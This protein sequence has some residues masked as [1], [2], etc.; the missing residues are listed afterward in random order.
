MPIGDT[1]K[2]WGATWLLRGPRMLIVGYFIVLAVIAAA[3]LPT[4]VGT[5]RALDRQQST[6]DVA[7]SGASELLVSALNQETAM[8]GYVLTGDPSFL[9]PYQLGSAQSV[10]ATRDLHSVSLNAPFGSEV[11]TT[12][13][14]LHSWHELAARAISDVKGHE[15]GAAQAVS[16][17]ATGKSRFDDFRQAQTR[18][19]N[20]VERD[21]RA[22]R[23][24]LHTQVVRSIVVLAVAISV[25]VFIGFLMWLWWRL[26]G[27]RSA[28]R[29]RAL[30]E[31]AV[32][33]QRA[34]DASSDG[35]FAKDLDG[36]HIL[37]NR[38]RAAAL[39][40]NADNEIVGH[41]VDDFLEPGAAAEAHQNEELV[42]RSGHERQ[43]QEILAFPDGPHIFSVTKSP[44][45]TSEG[46]IS[47]VVGIARDMTRE[48]ALLADRERLYQ[49]EHHLAETLQRSMLGSD[50]IADS[51]LEVC[52]RYIPA[53]ELAVG[54]DWY[55]TL[56]IAGGR[57][58]LVVGDAVGH[59]IEA[60][61]AMG[62]LRSAMAALINL[63][64]DPAAV[65]EALDQFAA[66]LPRARSS[67]CLVVFIDPGA[68]QIVYSCAGHMPPIVVHPGRH[69]DILAEHQDPPLA[70]KRLT[71][72]RNT[73]VPFPVNSV[74]LLYTDGLVERRNELVDVGLQR[75]VG[76]VEG[77]VHPSM[78][79]LC[80]RVIKRLV[81]PES[82]DDDVAMIAA[83]LTSRW[84]SSTAHPTG[85]E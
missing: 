42:M 6:F 66:T 40:G 27:R 46:Q 59:G 7:S 76:R 28:Q 71:P 56:P 38:A 47:G 43:F 61:T 3:I 33:L 68:E 58:A 65:L 73:V 82:Q 72:R 55:D 54:G 10:L 21:L 4:L 52:A 49:L 44:L 75:L 81:S 20:V 63:A 74:V 31:R 11:A 15:L 18:L 50:E 84:T 29:E 9:Q 22:G 25:G 39:T 34:I 60:V 62:Q 14:A 16:T 57:I 45:R 17:Q 85:H 35:L 67:T 53:A 8:R 37:A 24:S 36:R 51:R 78:N 1:A 5:L 83:R 23:Q 41:T 19:S 48:L 69:A 13:R 2:D 79:E 32:L 64:S 80:D 30:A 12:L 26:L 77:R 70:V